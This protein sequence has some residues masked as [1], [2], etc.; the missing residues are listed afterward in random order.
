MQFLKN[1]V[2]P[3]GFMPHGYCYSWAPGPIGLRVASD[4]LIALSCLS[5][6]IT[7]LVHYSRRRRD[8]PFRR[9]PV[10]FDDFRETLDALAIDWLL[11]NEPRPR[12]AVTRGTEKSA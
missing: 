8:I 2:F 11:F 3:G 12:Q 1:L 6:A 5:I 4:F 7:L 10:D 9:K